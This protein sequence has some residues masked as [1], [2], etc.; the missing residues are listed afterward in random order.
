MAAIA[1]FATSWHLN[2]RDSLKL[3]GGHMALVS[4]PDVPH[5]V[6]ADDPGA[7]SVPIGAAGCLDVVEEELS[8]HHCQVHPVP[9]EDCFCIRELPDG[10]SKAFNVLT[11]EARTL[12]E[13]PNFALEMYHNAGRAFFTANDQTEYLDKVFIMTA[14]KKVSAEPVAGSTPSVWDAPRPLGQRWNP[15]DLFVRPA[16]SSSTISSG[17]DVSE[18]LR[19]LLEAKFTSVKVNWLQG[20]SGADFSLAVMRRPKGDLRVWW[21]MKDVFEN[22]GFKTCDGLYWKWSGNFIQKWKNI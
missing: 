10:T 16:N 3:D 9:Q 1:K 4:S 11:G 2:I 14:L 22:I 17:K 19:F 18:T 21:N 7:S 12:P 13:D 6:V 20:K 5:D 15:E 8:Q